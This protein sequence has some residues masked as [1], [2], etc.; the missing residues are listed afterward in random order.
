RDFHCG[1]LFVGVLTERQRDPAV[2]VPVDPQALESGAC[3]RPRPHLLDRHLVADVHGSI[4]VPVRSG[5][6]RRDVLAA[7]KLGRRVQRNPDHLAPATGRQYEHERKNSVAH[8]P[9]TLPRPPWFPPRGAHVRGGGG[10]TRPA[11][12]GG[13]G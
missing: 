5:G 10:G 8:V 6:E 3:L 2:V 7:R 12:R 11:A 13:G 9:W 1:L 4:P